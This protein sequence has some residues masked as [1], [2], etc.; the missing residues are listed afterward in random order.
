MISLLLNV[1]STY[2]G[3]VRRCGYPRRCLDGVDG[4][5][6]VRMVSLP[7]G[8]VSPAPAPV[9]VPR[10]ATTAATTAVTAAATTATATAIAVAARRPR[11]GAASFSASRRRFLVPRTTT[12][13]VG[14]QEAELVVTGR[15]RHLLRGSAALAHL[16]HVY[17]D[18]G[19]TFERILR[20]RRNRLRND[21]AIRL[22][23]FADHTHAPNVLNGDLDVLD[24]DDVYLPR[25]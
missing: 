13:A 15:S 14:R 20:R 10:A 22:A 12:V 18:P 2:I 5:R 8:D 1:Q 23:N 9:P 7:L 16:G 24:Y 21:A 3:G 17:S 19:R 11:P 25:V 6:R 4:G